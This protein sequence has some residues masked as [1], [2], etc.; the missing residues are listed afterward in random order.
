MPSR[1]KRKSRQSPSTSH[2]SSFV[3]DDIIQKLLATVDSLTHQ[4]AQLTSSLDAQ[5]KL[6]E[7]LATQLKDLRQVQPVTP[8]NPS[9]SLGVDGPHCQVVSSSTLPYGCPPGSL[10]H[11]TIVGDLM[12][13]DADLAYF[14]LAA[15]IL[16]SAV[17]VTE[18]DRCAVVEHLADHDTSSNDFTAEFDLMR[19]ICVQAK[20][21]A[22]VAVWR[23]Q[24]K[25]T[26][27]RAR[28]LKVKFASVGDRN[29]F[30]SSFYKNLPQDF[31]TRFKGRRPSCRRDMTQIELQLIYRLR[32]QCWQMNQEAG[33]RQYVVRD[34]QILK[35][36][37]R[38]PR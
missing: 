9:R 10:F 11:K 31:S 7:E 28:P 33:S 27:Q 34:L 32:A 21:T 6:T 20:I 12:K 3:D 38:V 19:A 37:P 16:R 2:E 23:H 17:N 4:V 15:D 13:R 25:R 18:K 30:L 36:Q 29:A 24:P 5:M 14:S 35:L 22:P 26:S 8:T 1:K